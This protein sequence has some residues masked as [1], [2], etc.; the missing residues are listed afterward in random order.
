MLSVMRLLISLGFESSSLLFL[1]SIVAVKFSF[2]SSTSLFIK[3][4]LN[5]HYQ[6]RRM[7]IPCIQHPT[8]LLCFV[9]AILTS[10]MAFQPH[11]INLE[12]NSEYK[13]S[14]PKS[15]VYLLNKYKFSPTLEGPYTTI[16]RANT[17]GKHGPAKSAGGRTVMQ[18]VLMRKVNTTGGEQ[19]GAVPAEDE[20]H[21]ALYLG[22]IDIGTPPQRFNVDFDTGSADCWVP[23]ITFSFDRQS[24]LI[25]KCRYGPRGCPKAPKTRK[26]VNIK[27]FSPLNRVHSS[28]QMPS[29]RLAIMSL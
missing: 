26:T 19:L 9:S 1:L 11:K 18:K 15:Y 20:Q 7:I 8:A 24:M 12:L 25:L 22:P 23:L 3:S 21:D 28:R 13:P 2:F 5:Y 6:N 14:G 4:F 27:S 29:G 16:K 10:T 17:A